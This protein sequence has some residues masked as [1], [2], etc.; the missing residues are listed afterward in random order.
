MT[1]PHPYLS[2]SS[3]D[4]W[5]RVAH[6]NTELLIDQAGFSL[7]EEK[8]PA[9]NIDVMPSE[10]PLFSSFDPFCRLFVVDQNSGKVKMIRNVRSS[11][12]RSVSLFAEPQPLPGDFTFIDQ[13]ESSI[14]T[15]LALDSAG[16]L[17]LSEANKDSVWVFELQDRRLVR[18]AL[19]PSG[20]APKDMDADGMDVYVLTA[21]GL[22]VMNLSSDFRLLEGEL[23][24]QNFDRVCVSDGLIFVLENAQ[25]EQARVFPW[26]QPDAAINVPY[27]SDIVF[28]D[29][30]HLVIAFAPQQRFK[31]YLIKH[32]RQSISLLFEK[33][34]RA[35][36][37]RGDGAFR[38]PDSRIAYHSEKGIRYALPI[39]PIYQTRGRVTCFALDS[40]VYQNRWGL[41]F[42]DACIPRDC[43]VK[44]SF[45]TSDEEESFPIS[46]TLASNDRE[47]SSPFG[48]LLAPERSPKMP[49][50]SAFSEFTQISIEQSH[51]LYRRGVDDELIWDEYQKS[52]SE[53]TYETPVFAEPGRFLWVMLELQG[54]RKISPRVLSLRVQKQGH[55]LLS[56]LPKL[57]SRD[58]RV[59]DYMRR[60]LALP[61]AIL[62]EFDISSL[63]RQVMLDPHSCREEWLSWL[64]GFLGMSFDERFTPATRR[65]LIEE[66]AWLFR[67]RGTVAGL[68]RFLQIYAIHQ[69]GAGTAVQI[70]ERFKFRGHAG[71]H[72][73]ADTVAGSVLSVDY[74]LGAGLNEE[75][76]DID[77]LNT[78][79][80]YAHKFIVLIAANLSTDEAEIIDLIIQTHRPA[81]TA[82]EVCTVDAGMRIGRGLYLELNSFVGQS[83]GFLPI[84]LDSGTLGRNG[85]LGLPKTASTNT[86]GRVGESARI[87]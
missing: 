57:Y 14:Y 19:L 54:T 24:S 40:G 2:I 85:I 86:G 33:Y 73:P 49:P 36:G 15:G 21:F 87:G 45:Y 28:S 80:P 66:A 8:P 44:A 7:T 13:T 1:A 3:Q 35:K 17:F 38:T 6:K 16:H 5:R 27:A 76:I 78:A 61:E 22:G 64:A 79:D 72:D 26:R 4:Q 70:V 53:L 59:H 82:F 62:T 23:S 83:A 30:S 56:H 39:K 74:R 25:T 9:G 84:H 81:H 43:Q 18:Q 58:D 68:E 63:T 31:R 50:D 47:V 65:Q 60:Y 75:Q 34:L 51:R 48:D 41:A 69:L 20:S 29:S 42:I 12:Q 37:Y 67:F 52:S 32:N 10:S 55:Q 11:D 77:E 71:L 46:R